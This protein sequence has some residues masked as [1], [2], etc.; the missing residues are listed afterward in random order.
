[1]TKKLCALLLFLAIAVGFAVPA[2]A[3]ADP[4]GVAEIE[5]TTLTPFVDALS[6]IANGGLEYTSA[7]NALASWSLGSPIEDQRFLGSE[8]FIH[9]DK[10]VTDGDAASRIVEDGNRAVRMINPTSDGLTLMAQ[11][12]TFKRSETLASYKCEVGASL[13]KVSETSSITVVA[14]VNLDN[15]E[16]GQTE[17]R[18]SI[19]FSDIPV[20]QWV[21]RLISFTLPVET[22]SASLQIRMSGKGDVIADNVVFLQECD[23]KMIAAEKPVEKKPRVEGTPENMIGLNDPEHHGNTDFEYDQPGST[24]WWFVLD[25]P[26][27]ERF[28]TAENHTP[29]GSRSLY[30]ENITDI[31][32][33][34]Y[35]HVTD[36]VPGATY[37]L[38]WWYK[39]AT[40]VQTTIGSTG[41]FWDKEVP[42][43]YGTNFGPQVSGGYPAF[44]DGEWHEMV[45]EWTAPYPPHGGQVLSAEIYFSIG[46]AKGAAYF[47][48]ITM[49]MVKAPDP[50]KVVSDEAIYYTEWREGTISATVD[51][52]YKETL[53]GG[54]MRYTILD[55]DK[56]L[57]P[58]ATVP[59]TEDADG[60]ML[61]EGDFPTSVMEA[62]KTGQTYSYRAEIMDKDGNILQVAT[63]KI[64]RFDRP[65]YLGVDGIFR[66]NGKEYNIGVGNSA[67]TKIIAQNPGAGGVQIVLL[68][69][70]GD[71]DLID[72][73]DMAYEA[74][75]LVMLNMGGSLI[76]AGCPTQ[77]MQTR[78]TVRAA[79][80]HPAL[81]G[82]K[83]QDEPTQKETPEEHL[84]EAYVAIRE[85][86]PNHVIYSDDSVEGAFPRLARYTDY[87]D[88]DHYPG[89]ADSASII[90]YS[91]QKAGEASRGRKPFA[92]L[93]KAYQVEPKDM[94][95]PTIDEY[96]HYAY[97]TL[98]AGAAGW[99]YHQIGS[100]TAGAPFMDRPVWKEIVNWKESGE[101]DALLDCFVNGKYPLINAYAD[102]AI[103]WQ[104]YAV[105]GKLYAFVLNCVGGIGATSG[106]KT[107]EIPLTDA[108][109][110]K[111][112]GGFTA[113]CKWGG[114]GSIQGTD[115]LV[116]DSQSFTAEVWEITLDTPVAFSGYKMV[117]YNDIYKTPWAYQ[118][119]A[120]LHEK[121]IL[122][123]DISMFY[124]PQANV[125]RGD[126]AM[127]LVRALGLT[128]DATENF[129][130]VKPYAEYADAL[131]IGK[132]L[133]I[134]QGRGDNMYDPE[135]PATRAELMALT[136]RAMRLKG[137]VSGDAAALDAFAD[138]ANIPQ[139]AQGDV[140]AMVSLGIVKGNAD[141]TINPGGNTTR[142]EAAVIIDRVMEH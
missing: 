100:N 92:I 27:E 49:Y 11:T 57:M 9:N 30:M 43:A 127:F 17:K 2:V 115:K 128:A 95:M 122:N 45:L 16:G 93:Q 106:S 121:K 5:K 36:L 22:L 105:D 44:Q 79:K 81:F 1:M 28:S 42:G 99:G 63:N 7:A 130:D 40:P 50:A 6:I 131:A 97:Q 60:I 35:Q 70:E 103:K 86:D 14:I 46:G 54:S 90:H 111:T 110:G 48:D 21:R 72:K 113:N 19:P 88:T 116:I 114:E 52:Y 73:M 124:E 31:R 26:H 65:H 89:N 77:I 101:Q 119:V 37:Q 136:A 34:A 125:T 24:P 56:E 118:A 104:L 102:D 85:L 58:A 140:A 29:G 80:D 141:G 69:G 94:Y 10:R 61:A 78:D 139:W 74:G 12:A 4:F 67:T 133:G 8:V 134:F 23:E 123:E 71:I 82:Y 64:Y 53:R 126:Y 142:A 25:T 87:M 75:Y 47:D 112:L 51:N 109:T 129:A 66:K 39:V 18:F 32:G 41:K 117:K 84:L 98:F 68:V 120:K 138:K 76:C 83:L 91:S 96:R 59:F 15:G 38:S 107:V 108:S 3:E 13:Y 132:A 135:K 137:E 55:G 33:R 62:N 20:G